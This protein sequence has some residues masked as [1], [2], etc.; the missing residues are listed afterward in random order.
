[1]QKVLG[2]L[3]KD[4]G[5]LAKVLFSMSEVLGQ[6][7]K[8]LL[9]GSRIVWVGNEALRL[10]SK[11]LFVEPERLLGKATARSSSPPSP[12]TSLSGKGS[13]S[14]DGKESIGRRM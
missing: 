5:K 8:D 6:K 7:S 14:S 10:E 4:P 3:A 13:I 2:E 12:L 1:M 11:N 9:S